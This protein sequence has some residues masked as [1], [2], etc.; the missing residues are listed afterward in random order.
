[1]FIVHP[2]AMV[3]RVVAA[4]SESD[5]AHSSVGLVQKK[6]RGNYPP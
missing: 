3:S 4:F 2:I 1:M 5:S 6:L